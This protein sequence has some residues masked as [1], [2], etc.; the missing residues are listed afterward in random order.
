MFKCEQFSEG[1]LD[2]PKMFELKSGKK[3]TIENSKKIFKAIVSQRI[4]EMKKILEFSI[5][6][7]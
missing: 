6:S 1:D 5:V 4:C 7:F 3:Y 2:H